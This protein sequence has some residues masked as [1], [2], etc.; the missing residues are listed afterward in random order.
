MVDK[1]KLFLFAFFVSKSFF[2]VNHFLKRYQ[3]SLFLSGQEKV[4][5]TAP[6]LGKGMDTRKGTPRLVDQSLKCFLLLYE[7]FGRIT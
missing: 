1:K 2:F 7:G 3:V 4:P 5:K 6:F